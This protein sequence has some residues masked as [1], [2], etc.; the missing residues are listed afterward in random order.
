MG[1]VFGVTLRYSSAILVVITQL[2][3]DDFAWTQ[4]NANVGLPLTGN[5]E[6]G[7]DF[8]NPVL[9]HESSYGIQ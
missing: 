5:Q 3:S 7:G 6:I 8:S 4:D 9:T 1:M 2:G